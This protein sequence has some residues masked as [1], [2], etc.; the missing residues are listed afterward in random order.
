MR[1]NSLKGGTLTLL[2]TQIVKTI[3]RDYR[4]QIIFL[5]QGVNRFGAVFALLDL[6]KTYCFLVLNIYVPFFSRKYVE[7]WYQTIIPQSFFYSIEMVISTYFLLNLGLEWIL[8][9]VF[10]TLIKMQRLCFDDGYFDC[11]LFFSSSFSF[12]SSTFPLLYI[13]RFGLKRGRLV[14]WAIKNCI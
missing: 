14:E 1:S 13:R 2:G 4:N 11:T 3:V 8:K 6:G 5:I 12:L 9:C 7:L 10:N